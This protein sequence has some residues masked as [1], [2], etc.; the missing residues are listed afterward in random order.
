MY[1][2]RKMRPFE[3]I[4]GIGVGGFKKMMEQVN[5][6]VMYFKNFS[7]CHNLLPVQ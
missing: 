1:E 6:T 4:P 3:T 5:L 2:N 7:K